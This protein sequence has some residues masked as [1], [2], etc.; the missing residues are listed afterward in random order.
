MLDWKLSMGAVL[1]ALASVFFAHR[2][3]QKREQYKSISESIIK[4]K[5][6]FVPF[7]KALEEQEANP[8]LLVIENFPEQDQAA[9]KLA[10]RLTQKKQREFTFRWKQ[11]SQLH[12]EFESFST[13][14][15][16]AT[17]VDDL[18]KAS[19]A[20]ANSEDYIYAQNMKRRHKVISL[21][22]GALSVL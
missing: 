2:L 13:L 16:I 17:E 14:A 11:Y 15:M 21:V 10:L 1:V 3:T 5:E 19:P 7:L 6:S 12:K 4:F 20:A 8:K 18:S 9:R 22:E